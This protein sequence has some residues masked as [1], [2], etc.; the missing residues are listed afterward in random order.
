MPFCSIDKQ[1]DLIIPA[2]KKSSMNK[3]KKVV[4]DRYYTNKIDGILLFID[5]KMK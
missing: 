5:T 2:K 3:L 4:R 1:Q